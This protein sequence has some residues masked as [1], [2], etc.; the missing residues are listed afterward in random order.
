MS[1][2]TYSLGKIHLPENKK[3]TSVL[4]KLSL[5]ISFLVLAFGIGALFSSPTIAFVLILAS[6]PLFIEEK[7]DYPLQ[8]KN[9]NAPKYLKTYF[10]AASILCSALVF[11]AGILFMFGGSL[12]FAKQINLSISFSFLLIGLG[13]LLS[14]TQFPN[15]FHAIQ[16]FAFIILI[17]NSM[18]ILQYLFSQLVSVKVGVSHAPLNLEITLVLLC[19][20]ILLRWPARGLMGMFTTDSISSMYALKLLIINVIVIFILGFIIL[21]GIKM[22]M[23]VLYEAI[24]ALII[25]LTVLTITFAWINIRLLYRFELE[26][27][28]MKEELRVHN[29]SL[30]LGNE[31]LVKEMME[32]QETNKEYI[33]KLNNREKYKEAIESLE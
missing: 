33:D 29:I 16:L 15:R 7:L 26:R 27:F 18:A 12:T 31:D 6:I 9:N 1:E 4:Q 11:L 19:L 28:V 24:A 3:L 10:L 30:K 17:I 22:G 14:R 25:L 13:L 21:A 23:Y 2:S 20:A 8:S 32:L 5:L